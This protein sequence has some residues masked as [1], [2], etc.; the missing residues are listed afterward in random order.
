MFEGNLGLTAKVTYIRGMAE[1]YKCG[2]CEH[3]EDQCECGRYCWL[4]MS[5]NNVRLCQDGNLYCQECREV[6]EMEAQI[7]SR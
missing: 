6:C 3:P 7:R 1:A 4:C 5:E 2:Q